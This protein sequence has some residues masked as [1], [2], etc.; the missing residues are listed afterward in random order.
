MSGHYCVN[1]LD[2]VLRLMK[3]HVKIFLNANID[4]IALSNVVSFEKVS[5]KLLNCTGNCMLLCTN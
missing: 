5:K 1:K 3:I 4:C 2:L